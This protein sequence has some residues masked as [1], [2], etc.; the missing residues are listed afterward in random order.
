M[1]GVSP[2]NP[3]RGL[4]P[5]RIWIILILKYDYRFSEKRTAMYCHAHLRLS[6]HPDFWGIFLEEFPCRWL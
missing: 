4:G 3:T 6:C 1:E 2:S 5:K